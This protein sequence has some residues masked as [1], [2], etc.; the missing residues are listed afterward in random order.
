MDL[1]SRSHRALGFARALGL[2]LMIALGCGCGG[3]GGS[4][5]PA[6]AQLVAGDFGRA[7]DMLWW[8]LE[9]AAIPGEM[10]FNRDAVPAFVL[11]Y[12]W[13]VD[14]DAD[15]DGATDLRPAVTYYKRD[16]GGQVHTADI[17]SVTMEDLWAVEGPVSSTTGSVGVTLTGSTFRFETT[18][19]EDAALAG[20][21]TRSQ[22]TFTTYHTFGR[23]LGDHCEDQL[24]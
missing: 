7:G 24:R 10:I 19:A 20:V 21:T 5:C 9:V 16:T 8:T 13:A 22:S 18:V 11:E 3:G 1:P 15:G 12:S 17:L 2:T 23:G 4:S 14:V 6:F